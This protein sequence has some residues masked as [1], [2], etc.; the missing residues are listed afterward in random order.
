[1]EYT[2]SRFRHQSYRIFLSRVLQFQMQQGSSLWLKLLQEQREPWHLARIRIETKS[3][4]T[5]HKLPQSKGLPHFPRPVTSTSGPIFKASCP[6]LSL[7]LVCDFWTWPCGCQLQPIL[8]ALSPLA[9]PFLLSYYN[10]PRGSW[11]SLRTS[12]KMPQVLILAGQ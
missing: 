8:A 6:P 4:S 1:M 7:Y 10:R 3:L 11:G 9:M 2:S 12:F 5:D